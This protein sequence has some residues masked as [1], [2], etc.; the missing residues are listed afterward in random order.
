M[1]YES[2]ESLKRRIES[3]STPMF[4]GQAAGLANAIRARRGRKYEEQLSQVEQRN[5]ANRAQE[6]A[7]LLRGAETGRV[8]DFAGAA[9]LDQAKFTDPTVQ[10]LAA[11]LRLEKATEKP[12]AVP[13]TARLYDPRTQQTLLDAM[14]DMGMGSTTDLARYMAASPEN[15]RLMLEFRRNPY[16]NAGGEFVNPYASGNETPSVIP[17]TVPPQEMPE[18]KA[19]QAAAAAE[20]TAQGALTRGANA[21]LTLIDL[22]EPLLDVAT[23]S[24][25]GAVRDVALGVVGQ[26][27]EAGEAAAQLKAIGGLLVSKMPRMEGPQSNY[28][29][30]LYREMAGQIGDPT[31]P[32]DVRKAALETIR[33]LNEKYAGEQSNTPTPNSNEPAEG[34]TATN[35]QTG[36]KIIFRNG[37][38]VPL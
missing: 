13:A 34:D 14:P 5:Q 10:E 31:V 19:S 3:L 15:R 11:K 24:G 27:T 25:I 1:A 26:S 21:A 32:N 29:V 18:F 9:T 28:D 23:G 33:S 37:Q 30:Q 22:A 35:P 4:S 38:W 20:A 7:M 6:L 8:G 2:P 17:K 12:M 16:L 36:Q